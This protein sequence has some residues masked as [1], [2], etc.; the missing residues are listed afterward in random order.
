M[1]EKFDIT[2]IHPE[3]YNA[4]KGIFRIVDVPLLRVMAINGE[5]DKTGP[6]YKESVSA[7]YNI[8][9]SIRF[10][11][12]KGHEVEGFIDFTVPALEVLWSMKNGREVDMKNKYQLAWEMFVVVP[13]FVTQ[14]VVDIAI[15][16]TEDRLPNTRYDEIHISTLEEKKCI[17]TLWSGADSKSSD[18]IE[19]LYKKIRSRKYSPSMRYHE[20]YLSDPI[21]TNKSKLKKVIRQPVVNIKA[22]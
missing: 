12:K 21:R 6:R 17:Q 18:G 4:K 7:L 19:A 14:A 15:K 5:G 9:Y 10:M 16:Q 3:L 1:L 13:G 8:A 22:D 11:P 20:I 2:K